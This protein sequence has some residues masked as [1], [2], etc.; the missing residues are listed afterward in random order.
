M[1][2]INHQGKKTNNNSIKRKDVS[3]AFNTF[4]KRV[5]MRAKI[6]G[7]NSTHNNRY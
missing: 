7:P 6:P 2:D 5:V 1:G 4:F 3:E